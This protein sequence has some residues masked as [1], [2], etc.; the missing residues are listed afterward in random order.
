MFKTALVTVL[1]LA[2]THAIVLA[3]PAAK[4]AADRHAELRKSPAVSTPQLRELG[5]D[6]LTYPRM[7]GSTSTQPLAA[8]IACRCLGLDYEWVGQERRLP[9][10]DNRARRLEAE[11]RL[12]EF[13]LQPKWKTPT[14]ER[15]ALI[16]S[17]LLAANQS[18]HEA[19]VSVIE[20]RNDIGLLARP[21]SATELSLAASKK[22]EL[23]VLP[24][25]LDA[26][27]FLVHSD[28]PLRSLQKGQ[29]QGIYLNRI[30]DWQELGGRP[31][32]IIAYHR[33]R[34]SGSEELMRTLVMS[35]TGFQTPEH[36][37]PNI[38]ES[39]MSSI[40]L[41]L[42]AD[43][44]GIGYSVHFYERYMMRNA[45]TRVIAVD[46]VEPTYETIRDR[47]YPY[48]C[49]VLVVIRKDLDQNAPARKL[50]DWLRSREGQ[51]VVR[52]SGYVPNTARER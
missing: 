5:F 47:K 25:A 11:A 30:R 29:V 34:S 14:E 10:W 31:G 46:G 8:L 35:G 33:E 49:D 4:S 24:C 7:C 27:V 28:N 21:P 2:S 9:G 18:T 6:V 36:G 17:G 1:C 3:Q 23:E 45:R 13:T 42:S 39:L 37:E 50:R 40:F 52:E 20:G 44:Q 15:L 26:F 41:A 16:I 43:K 22:I 19:Y 51:A 32:R 12:L 38:A 48:T